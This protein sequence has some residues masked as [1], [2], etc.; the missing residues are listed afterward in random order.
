MHEDDPHLLA[1]TSSFIQEAYEENAAATRSQVV[2]DIFVVNEYPVRNVPTK[3]RA[4]PCILFIFSICQTSPCL[5]AYDGLAAR[6]DLLRRLAVAPQRLDGEYDILFKL[7]PTWPERELFSAAGVSP[8]RIVLLDSDLGSLLGA[9]AVLITVNYSSSPSIQ[10]IRNNIP[11]LHVNTMSGQRKRFMHHL[12]KK[13]FELGLPFAW[14]G[15]E[16]WEWI[17]RLCYD[18]EERERVLS[19]QESVVKPKLA[20]ERTDWLECANAALRGGD[21]PKN[22]PFRKR[23]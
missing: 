1:L 11:L 18:R 5:H 13:F 12:D 21:W 9:T 22:L 2:D 6:L 17:D 4:K 8:E 19:L 23:V 16:T 7:H 14:S 20:G 15:E 3:A 10:A